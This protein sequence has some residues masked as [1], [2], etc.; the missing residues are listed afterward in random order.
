MAQEEE[1]NI[2]L[3]IDEVQVNNAEEVEINNQLGAEEQKVG[4][5][6]EVKQEEEVAKKKDPKFH[7]NSTRIEKILKFW[8]ENGICMCRNQT[9]DVNLYNY[10]WETVRETAEYKKKVAALWLKEVINAKEKG[11]LPNVTAEEAETRINAILFPSEVELFWRSHP[12]IKQHCLNWFNKYIDSFISGD[13]TIH[14]NRSKEDTAMRHSVAHAVLH[15]MPYSVQFEVSLFR[16]ALIQLLTPI[17]VV[18]TEEKIDYFLKINNVTR[19][20]KEADTEAVLKKIKI[21]LEWIE[22]TEGR[23]RPKNNILDDNDAFVYSMFAHLRNFNRDD[24]LYKKTYKTEETFRETFYKEAK[25]VLSDT[26][27]DRLVKLDIFSSVYIPPDDAVSFIVNRY[28]SQEQNKR[29]V[30]KPPYYRVKGVPHYRAYLR[31]LGK[32]SH[33]PE[34]N[35]KKDDDKAYILSQLHL[36]L[37]DKEKDN[38]DSINWFEYGETENKKPAFVK[39][40]KLEPFVD[41]LIDRGVN[42]PKA[43]EDSMANAF[44]AHLNRYNRPEKMHLHEPWKEALY[45]LIK[46]KGVSNRLANKAKSI[47]WFENETTIFLSTLK[48]SAREYLIRT[49]PIT[50]KVVKPRKKLS[51]GNTEFII[52]HFKLK[53]GDVEMKPEELDE[54]LQN[55]FEEEVLIDISEFDSYFLKTRRMSREYNEYCKERK[56]AAMRLSVQNIKDEEIAAKKDE[57]A[58]LDAFR[59]FAI[60]KFVSPHYAPYWADKKNDD[61]S[62]T[63]SDSDSDS[64]NSDNEKK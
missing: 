52:N 10:M 48:K 4:E 56:L 29:V 50:K 37:P 61:D 53:K 36:Q 25:K 13:W 17:N 22:K 41:Y 8:E 60:G 28:Y 26:V 38:I 59:E 7:K 23:K 39:P 12:A 21:V 24:E 5:V 55:N 32:K 63:E 42:K 51:L 27:Y 58:W 45:K 14:F 3:D 54:Y 44:L 46:K 6:Q 40:E 57:L 30:E 47:R 18:F 9:K 62:D 31:Q 11:R 35:A 64:G 19:S 43:N 2:G 34:I 20:Q 1:V 15:Q 33:L 16:K 49:I